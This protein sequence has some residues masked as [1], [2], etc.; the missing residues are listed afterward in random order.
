MILPQRR[1]VAEIF[2]YGNSEVLKIKLIPESVSNLES[3]QML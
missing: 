2:K 3:F 1:R